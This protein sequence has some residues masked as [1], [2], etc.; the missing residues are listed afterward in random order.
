MVRAFRPPA[1]PYGAG[2]RGVDLAGRAGQAVLAVD[3]GV[4]SHAGV[5]AGRGTVTVRHAAGLA[6]TY[7]P[8]AAE[9]TAGAVLARG[10]P[11]GRLQGARSHC[12]PTACLHLGARRGAQY[13]DP[14]VFLRGERVRL[15]PLR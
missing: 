12:A 2:H 8:V 10:Q 9:V 11:L 1:T 14:L 15:L 13:V 3:A 7:E 6:S 4:V 5:V